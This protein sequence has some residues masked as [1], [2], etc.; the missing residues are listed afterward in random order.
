MSLGGSIPYHL[1]QNKAI[2]RSLFIELLGR[3]NRFKNISDY[4]YVGFGGPFLEDFKFLH[5]ALRIKSMISLEMDRNVAIRQEF[6]KP[7]SCIEIRQQTSADF[8]IKHH[9]NSA[10]IVWFDYAIPKNLPEQLTETRKLISELDAGDIFKITLN[11]SAETLGRPS[12]KTADL[13]T[14]RVNVALDRL[15]GYGKTTLTE[16][17]VNQKNYPTLLLNAIMDAARKGVEGAQNLYV[18]PLSAFV[19][20]DGQQM[21]TATGIILDHKEKAEFLEKSRVEHWRH[22]CLIW[23][24]PKAI[25]VPDLSAKE[26]LHIEALL[27]DSKSEEILKKLGYFVGRDKEDAEELMKN[28]IDYYRLSPWFSRVLM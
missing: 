6:N 10:S 9:F 4:T 19:Y 17:D 26:R 15:A 18:Q 24:S 28:F 21:L 16:E 11:A 20:K 7:L 12:E 27:P 13:H 1:R 14:H 23:D 5:S 25:S 3:I 8:L 22:S 2:D